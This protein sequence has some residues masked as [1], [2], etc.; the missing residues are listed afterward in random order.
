MSGKNNT[1]TVAERKIASIE[2]YFANR[3]NKNYKIQLAEKFQL[4]QV[5]EMMIFTIDD[6]NSDNY[7]L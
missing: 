1:D 7:F 6:P 2:K 5:E 3:G 4:H